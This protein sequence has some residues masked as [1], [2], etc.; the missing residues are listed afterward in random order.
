MTREE[1]GAIAGPPQA[2]QRLFVLLMGSQLALL[3]LAAAG[4]YLTSLPLPET[5]S[6]V[7]RELAVGL[8]GGGLSYLAA[9]ALTRSDTAVGATL[10]HHCRQLSRLFCGFSWPQI[11]CLALAAGICEE[12]LFRGFL[13]GW[14]ASL[15]GPVT[16]I[17]L[18]S[19]V[20][21]LL[22][23]VSPIYFA[24]TLVMGLVLGLAYWLSGDLL[25]VMLWHSVYDLV[26]IG[27]LV[28]YP[29]WLGV[30]MG[31][32]PVDTN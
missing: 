20:F 2:P 12:L 28:K 29:H 19:L 31:P 30:P 13:Q 8:V 27:L 9:M 32:G 3:L 22:H 15:G 17:A 10:R 26:A 16:G 5:G 6:S 4:F 23:A 24:V 11:V 25:G 14:L 18:A 7:L 21:A 1:G